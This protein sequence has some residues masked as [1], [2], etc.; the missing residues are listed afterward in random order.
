MAVAYEELQARIRAVALPEED[1]DALI[2][3]AIQEFILRRS[4]GDVRWEAARAAA[5]AVLNGPRHPFDPQ[6]MSR[7]YQQQ[8]GWT[9]DI[10][11]LSNEEL[12]AQGDAVL[13]ALFRSEPPNQRDAESLFGIMEK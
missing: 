3:A 7:R 10:S 4:V 12:E 1:P 6:A 8:F 2:E 11:R 5:Q 13:D 9:G